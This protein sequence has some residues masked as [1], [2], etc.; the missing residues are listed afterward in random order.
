MEL[1]RPVVEQL[2]WC[3]LYSVISASAALEAENRFLRKQRALY[4]ERTVP[5]GRATNAT[6]LVLGWLGRWE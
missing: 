4:Q 1:L 3:H 6:R 5:P 2:P